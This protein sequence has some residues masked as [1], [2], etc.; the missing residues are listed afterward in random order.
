[1]AASVTDA[2]GKFALALLL[3]GTYRVSVAP[4]SEAYADTTL[5]GVTVTAGNTTS[6]GTIVLTPVPAPAALVAR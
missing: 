4:T 3:P 5:D 2:D 1:V 6:L